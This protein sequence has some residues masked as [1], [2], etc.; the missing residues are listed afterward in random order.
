M[1]I[2]AVP[3]AAVGDEKVTAIGSPLADT[4]VCAAGHINV[5]AGGFDG[6]V[7]L[8]PHWTA[9]IALRTT[10]AKRRLDRNEGGKLQET[11]YG[12]MRAE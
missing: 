12:S 11:R 5:I 4:I 9:P 2:G 10:A 1:M 3:P 7:G 8:L 6:P